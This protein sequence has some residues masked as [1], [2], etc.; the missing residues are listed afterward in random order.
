MSFNLGRFF[1]NYFINDIFYYC[2]S[3]F[4]IFRLYIIEMLDWFSNFFL[5]YFTF[6]VFVLPERLPQP[7]LLMLLQLLISVTVLQIL[8]TSFPDVFFL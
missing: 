6:C 7:Y 4:Y 8:R 3:L 1:L 2:F 5:L